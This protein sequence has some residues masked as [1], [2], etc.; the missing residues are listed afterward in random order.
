MA[1]EYNLP[2]YIYSLVQPHTGVVVWGRRTG[3]TTGP[4]GNFIYR[5]IQSM[6]RSLGMGVVPT[7][8]KFLT[9][10]IPAMRD[11]LGLYGMKE[12][13]HFKVNSFY[14]DKWNVKKPFSYP[15]KPKNFFHICNGTGIVIA[16]QDRPETMG[17]GLP[18]DWLFNDESKLS[19]RDKLNESMLTLASRNKQWDNLSNHY[20]TLFLSDKPSNSKGNWLF[21]YRE[22]MDYRL[23]Q[24]IIE[25]E[26]LRQKYLIPLNQKGLSQTTINGYSSKIRKID[27][28]LNH[29]RKGCTFFSEA[30]TIDNIC[31]I[32][33]EAIDNFK[34]ILTDDE[35]DRSVLNKTVIGGG[36]RFYFRLDED[37]H[38]KDAPYYP[39]I[40]MLVE[41]HGHANLPEKDCRWDADLINSDPL[42]ISFDHNNAIN[43]ITVR[44]LQGTNLHQ[45]SAL[46]VLGED[47]QYL[48][49]L[50]DKFHDYYKYKPNRMVN[51]FYDK[52]SYPE[53]DRNNETSRD[54]VIRLLRSKGW[55][56]NPIDLGKQPTYKARY[57]L[58][59]ALLTG[60]NEQGIT[61]TYNKINNKDWYIAMMSAQT[62][63]GRTGF[64][65]DKASERQKTVPPQH[66]TH[67][68][69]AT[70]V[71]VYGRCSFVLSKGY[72]QPEITVR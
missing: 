36:Q 52:T 67:F 49:H 63:Q 11:A 12:D 69:E 65:K 19:D 25:V 27:A 54:V 51:Y 10:M 20:S 61:F 21:D 29:L 71:G 16:S 31:N 37:I 33:I 39:F 42:D 58:W 7:Y 1:I 23:I 17:N 41:K 55:E 64:E 8:E 38:G 70:D 34:R 45:L 28:Y 62:K 4:L 5:N 14:S 57:D 48:D 15:E 24:E 53:D 72:E 46:Y 32:G 18:V 9:Q 56:V 66:A 2:Q 13:V 44:Q 3:K 50:V 43:S 47:K 35:F 22:Q 6:P 40:D 59:Y 30:S 60:K 68:T 26:L